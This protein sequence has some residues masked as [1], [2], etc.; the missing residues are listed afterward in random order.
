MAVVEPQDPAADGIVAQ[1]RDDEEARRG[2]EV[3]RG[4]GRPPLP[5]EPVFEARVELV[6][7]RAEA[8]ERVRMLGIALLD[9]DHRSDEEPLDLRHGARELRALWS[10]ERFE[11]RLGDRI[12]AAIELGALDTT[13]ARQAG[14]PHPPV[15]VARLD[16]D[17]ALGHECLQDSTQVPGVESELGAERA[18]VG[19]LLADLPED[20]RMAERAP[21]REER[22]VERADALRD[23]PAEPPYL[24]DVLVRDSLTLVRELSRVQARAARLWCPGAGGRP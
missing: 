6:E 20:A 8:R 5:I 21:T 17:E 1:G 3:G 22:L 24:R 13:G 11:N 7:V 18:E 12:R 10:A 23:D 16:G 19:A 15:R 4:I 9:A 2:D 14:R